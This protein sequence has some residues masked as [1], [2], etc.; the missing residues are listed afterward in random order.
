MKQ[1]NKLHIKI[2][3]AITLVLFSF[4][5]SCSNER[6]IH[7]SF[8]GTASPRWCIALWPTWMRSPPGCGK[9]LLAKAIANES[10]ANFIS[11]KEL[12]LLDKQMIR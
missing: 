6:R 10:G 11:V 9:T 7:L 1:T 5:N 3:K 2:N 12:E 8:S 4:S